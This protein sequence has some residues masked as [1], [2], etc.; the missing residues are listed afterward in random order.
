MENEAGHAT[1][2]RSLLDAAE[3][4]E[5]ETSKAAVRG[6]LQQVNQLFETRQLVSLYFS[7]SV[8]LALLDFMSAL[9]LHLLLLLLLLLL[10]RLRLASAQLQA[11]DR[12][13]PRRTLATK[14]PE[15]ISDRMPKKLS[16]DMPGKMSDRI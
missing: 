10:L 6:Y 12:S 15:D 8:K 2:I 14:N 9:I 4:I 1:A 11:L 13:G 3:S 16:E 5:D 7:P